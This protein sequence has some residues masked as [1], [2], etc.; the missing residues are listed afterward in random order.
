M[1][2]DSDEEILPVRQENIYRYDS[3]EEED[4]EAGETGEHNYEIEE[5][6]FNY[7]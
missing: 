3:N 2:I 5:I 1:E 7:Y 6:D 4:D